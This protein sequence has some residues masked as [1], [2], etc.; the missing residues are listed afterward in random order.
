MKDKLRGFLGF[1]GL[2]ED[3]YGEYGPTNAPRPFSSSP[4]SSNPSGP[5]PPCP[6]RAPF[7]PSRLTP[8]PFAHEQPGPADSLARRAHL[9]ARRFQRGQPGSTDRDDQ[10]RAG[11]LALSPRARRR[12]CAPETYDD[13]RRITDLLRSNRA[14][15]LE[16]A[17]RRSRSRAKAGGLHRGHGLRVEREDGDVDPWRVLDQ[18]PG[19]ARRSGDER[20]TARR[21]LSRTRSGM[22]FVHDLITLYIWILIIMMVSELVPGHELQGGLAIT[23]RI[24]ADITEPVLRPL[25]AILPRPRIGGVGI[26]FSVF[27]AV[28]ILAIINSYI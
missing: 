8:H 3:E 2:V 12:H 11:R 13:S 4:R 21:E 23:K 7:P 15:V 25:R 16:H 1:L 24:L 10:R 18:S 27:V 20:A 9:G 6:S 5:P 22:R 17:R 26:D 14:V 28:I 19:N